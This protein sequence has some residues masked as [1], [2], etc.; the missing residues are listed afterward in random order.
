MAHHADAAGDAE[1][2]RTHALNAAERAAAL[3]SHREA[4][5]Q[6]ERALRYTPEHN[7]LE[8]AT[9]GWHPEYPNWFAHR[10][11]PQQPFAWHTETPTAVVVTIVDDKFTI[12]GGQS[13]S[14]TVRPTIGGD[15]SW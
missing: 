11:S 12:G 5:E 2:A 8:G 10:V 6:Y 9:F 1:A 13:M 3:G 15:W 4:L 7:P 14:V